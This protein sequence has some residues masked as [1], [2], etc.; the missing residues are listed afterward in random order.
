MRRFLFSALLFAL[1]AALFAQKDVTKFLGIPVDGTKSEMTQKLKA[2]GFV[3]SAIDKE[4]L[5][6]EFNGT[7]VNVYIVT[8]NNKVSRI[9]V[10]DAN[11]MNETDIRIR[12]NKLCNQF[13]NNKKYLSTTED[14]IIPDNEDISYEMTVH[15]KRYEAVFYQEPQTPDSTE[16]TNFTETL[17][18]KYTKEEL[19]NPTEEIQ[20]EI[21]Q[22]AM[23]AT[24]DKIR[25]KPVWFMIFKDYGEYHISMYYDNVYN[26][27][28]GDDL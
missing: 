3:T 19:A 21:I 2:K 4:I 20:K 25:K 28:N 1:S 24:M 5:E 9:M 23:D 6:G 12:F 13:A 10:S 7:Q 18:S 14:Y 22:A 15:N 26:M 16:T 8:T 17:L 27:A 11:T